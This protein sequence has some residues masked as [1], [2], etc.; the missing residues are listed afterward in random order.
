MRATKRGCSHSNLSQ[1]SSNFHG[2]KSEMCILISISQISVPTSDPSLSCPKKCSSCNNG[3]C[4]V[5]ERSFALVTGRKNKT[6]CIPC[7]TGRNG[8][9][10]DK[11]QCDSGNSPLYNCALD[12]VVILC[13]GH[14]SSA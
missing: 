1:A 14:E 5:C 8:K 6:A 4:L 10:I 12:P 3:V 9:R 2:K 7:A 13:L 11:S